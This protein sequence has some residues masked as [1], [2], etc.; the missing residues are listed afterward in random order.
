VVAPGGA[1][2]GHA[3]TR[4]ILTS[5]VNNSYTFT[6]GTSLAAPLVAGLASLLK[7]YN[8]SLTNDDIRQIIRLT[9]D[10]IGEIPYVNNFNE[11]YGYGRINSGNALQ[12]IQEPNE[13][14]QGDSHGGFAT[15]TN[16]NNWTYIG[17]KWGLASGVY[18]DVDRYTVTKRI[19]FDLPFCTPPTVWLRERQS[20][21]LSNDNPNDGFPRIEITNITE[22]GFDVTYYV[23]YVR[24]NYLGQTINKWV[25]STISNSKVSY[26]AVGV[27]D[28]SALANSINGPVIL[29]NNLQATFS[30]NALPQE[31]TVSWS[32]NTQFL[33]FVSGQGTENY[34]VK[35][36]RNVKGEAWVRAT[37]TGPCGSTSLEKRFWVGAPNPPLTINFDFNHSAC[38]CSGFG[39]DATVDAFNPSY[40][41]TVY[42]W[43]TDP[44]HQLFPQTNNNSKVS[45]FMQTSQTHHI[46]FNVYASNTCGSSS[47]YNQR[48][49][50]SACD[51][52]ICVDC[53]LN[54]DGDPI[55][56]ALEVSPIP[57]MYTLN[58]NEIEPTNSSI[59]WIL[60]IMGQNGVVYIV[61]TSQLPETI[62]VSNLQPG[63]YILHARRGSYSEQHQIIIN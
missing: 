7:G 25:P 62:D 23:Y 11:Q 43:N 34:V 46:D 22:T 52:T 58:V 18:Y 39:I 17:N 51:C 27:P 38:A 60:R 53:F 36:K 6:S 8:N 63:I 31:T 10:Q 35:A 24:Y 15:K 28:I 54:P 19:I 9:A 5:N 12:F 41:N 3:D 48:L 13:V 30:L 49:D 14:V 40:A 4:N 47:S 57:T 33:S 20:V 61:V 26:T 56:R 2:S 1:G 55:V 21:C 29:C 44:Y 32:Y 59:P 42:T 50:L 45:L 37:I 16:L